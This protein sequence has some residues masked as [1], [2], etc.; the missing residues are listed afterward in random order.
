MTE[1]VLRSIRRWLITIA[2]LLSVVLFLQTWAG[3]IPRAVTATANMAG[4][5]I[6]LVA[7]LWLWHA[8]R[9]KTDADRDRTQSASES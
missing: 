2:F 6:G 3:P 7:L 1:A 4:V 9:G 5:G 8:F